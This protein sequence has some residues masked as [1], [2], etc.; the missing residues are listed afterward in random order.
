MQTKTYFA[1]SVPAALEVARKELGPDAMLVGSRPSPADARAFGRL[2]VTFA[3]DDAQPGAREA[4]AGAQHQKT[5]LDD[6]RTQIAALRDAV[7]NVGGVIPRAAA[8]AG[9]FADHMQA[10]DV[11]IERKMDA[12]GAIVSRLC[13][14]GLS[15]EFARE[16]VL[17]ASQRQ[18]EREPSVT[19]E[20]TEKIRVK[21]FAEMKPRDSRTM[22]FIGPP[23]R[24]KTTSLVKIA[25]R[26]GLARRVPVR[27]Y[28]AGAH[29]I[30][31]QEQMSRFAAI[32]GVPFQAF[33]SLESLHLALNGDGWRGLVLIDTPGLCRTDSWEISEFATFFSRR[34]EIEKHLVLRAEGRTADLLHAVS[35]FSMMGPTHLLFTGIDEALTLG[36]MAEVL[37]RAGIPAAFAGTG[38]DIPDDIEEAN[39]AR[40]ARTVCNGH[41]M[42]AAAA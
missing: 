2:E 6:L 12:S 8:F 14:N 34:P 35:A 16:L 15:R 7:G 11:E 38:R 9:G 37:A 13:A 17:S 33:E 10:A 5:E 22:A 25:L 29:G 40:W 18:G 1:T 3:F 30:G 39:A 28:S 27:I 20:L 26:C 32:L 36:A 31:G 24:G 21:L 4:P 23:G 41:A 42:A 19:S